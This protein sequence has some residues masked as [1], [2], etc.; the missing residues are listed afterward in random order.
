M[1]KRVRVYQRGGFNAFEAPVMPAMRIA[2]NGANVQKPQYTDEQLV[3]AV[4]GIIGE[5]GG[6]PE[7]ALQQL[8]AAGVDQAKANAVVSSAIEYINQQQGSG[9]QQQQQGPTEEEQAQAE[10]EARMQ[11][12]QQ[13]EADRQARYNTQMANDE[14]DLA[15]SDADIDQ[16]ASDYL[17]R[18]GGALPSKRTFVKNVMKLAKK[19]AGGESEPIKA[20]DT[21]IPGAKGRKFGLDAFVGNLKNKSNNYLQEQDI[22]AMHSMLS[23]QMQTPYADPNSYMQEPEMQ[24]GGLR[25]GQQR[26]MERRANRMAGKVPAA[27]FNAQQQM[28]PQGINIMG[29]PGMMPGMAQMGPK[30]FQMPARGLYAGGPRLANIEVHKTGLFGR[31]KAWTAT[32]DNAGYYDPNQW[33]QDMARMNQANQQT[34][35]KDVY[36]DNKEE[37]TNTSTD[38]N[39]EVKNEE[40]KVEAGTTEGTGGG[41]TGNTT[42]GT[43]GAAGTEGTETPGTEEPDVEEPG[44][45]NPDEEVEVEVEDPTYEGMGIDYARYFPGTQSITDNLNSRTSNPNTT[46]NTNRQS[47]QTQNSSGVK[48][49]LTNGETVFKLKSGDT[50]SHFVNKNGKIYKTGPKIGDSSQWYEIKDPARIQNI[51]SLS[52]RSADAFDLSKSNK[53]PGIND[54]GM[55]FPKPPVEKKQPIN[56][57]AAQDFRGYTGTVLGPERTGFSDK[58]NPAADIGY[59]WK[60]GKLYK[61]PDWSAVAGTE[62]WY[63]ITDPQRI[64]T[65]TQAMKAQKLMAPGEDNK[66]NTQIAQLINNGKAVK[67]AIPSS[68]RFA[69]KYFDPEYKDLVIRNGKLYFE[70]KDDSW[71]EVKDPKIVSTVMKEQSIGS[72]PFM[73]SGPASDAFEMDSS[74]GFQM[75]GLTDQ[76][77]QLYR[78]INGGEDMSIPTLNERNTADPYFAYGGLYRFQGNGD[79]E[80]DSETNTNKGISIDYG[81]HVN[82][83]TGGGNSGYTA[84]NNR[85]NDQWGNQKYLTDDELKTWETATKDD[86]NLRLTDLSFAN[87]D[88][89]KRDPNYKAWDDLKSKGVNVGD[90]REGIDYTQMGQGSQGNTGYRDP[91][92]GWD[93]TG[94]MPWITS[95]NAPGGYYNPQ[96]GAMYPPLFGGRRRFSPPGGVGYAGSWLKQKGMPFDPRT[97]QMLGQMPTDLPLTKLEVTKSSL[98]RKRPKE[99]T[100]YFGN[101]GQLG[102]NLPQGK[103]N[104]DAQQMSEDASP[105]NSRKNRFAE[106]LMHTPGFR[107]IGARMYEQPE[108]PLPEGSEYTE[109]QIPTSNLVPDQ[110]TVDLTGLPE[111]VIPAVTPEEFSF[112]DQQRFGNVQGPL[113]QADS[114]VNNFNYSPLLSMVPQGLVTPEQQATMQNFVGPME[115]PAKPEYPYV[116]EFGFPVSAPAEEY[117]EETVTPATMGPQAQRVGSYVNEFGFPVTQS[118]MRDINGNPVAEGQGI[119]SNIV[120]PMS[121]M[122]NLPNEQDYFNDL[123]LEQNQEQRIANLPPDSESYDYYQDVMQPNRNQDVYPFG[124]QEGMTEEAFG[125]QAA[126]NLEGF[127]PMSLPDESYS[128]EPWLTQEMLDAQEAKSQA[129]SNTRRGNTAGQTG[130]VNE[131]DGNSANAEQA[132]A[133]NLDRNGLFN[134]SKKYQE[135]QWDRFD[136]LLKKRVAEMR[137]NGATEDQIRQFSEKKAQNADYIIRYGVD[138]STLGFL[139]TYYDLLEEQPNNKALAKEFENYLKLNPAGRNFDIERYRKEQAY[140]AKAEKQ[141]EAQRL[142]EQ[143][144]LEQQKRVKS[145]LPS[146]MQNSVGKSRDGGPILPK[147]QFGPTTGRLTTNP[148]LVGFSDIDLLNAQ[149]YPEVSGSVNNVTGDWWSASPNMPTVQE[150]GMLQPEQMTID[151]NQQYNQQMKR[152]YDPRGAAVKFKVKDMYNVDFEKGVNRA[153]AWADQTLAWTGELGDRNKGAQRFNNLNSGIYGST[154]ALKRGTYETNSGLLEPDK[155]GFKGVIRDGGNIKR[156]GGPAYKAGGV[157]YMSADQVK[158]F[159]AEGGELEFV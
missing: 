146:W 92:S 72:M 108:L 75:G 61:T 62:Q 11:E 10:E 153:N 67:M 16:F 132:R 156:Q 56:F 60:N 51:I 76:Q 18:N 53:S 1:K 90:F 148:D 57:V 2:Q 21:D 74:E 112:A 68:E 55:D 13:E 9:Q 7:D 3:S 8:V 139:M 19:A 157:T 64:A 44:V 140:I 98:F 70:V 14:A 48:L 4:M 31:P 152:G 15:D 83:P 78:F 39:A 91:Y 131:G 77:A 135:A 80:T 93:G 114:A 136:D 23:Q 123:Q 99:Y 115:E 20:D 94:S 110:P 104:A 12:Q 43:E 63:E 45:D 150:T 40:A 65:I 137:A 113:S 26:R 129:Q 42:V 107:K 100:M 154:K 50:K 85:V 41:N 49:N 69:S 87:S 121:D 124:D 59:T 5:Q 147:A 126:E 144:K 142:K 81:G 158:K 122:A 88:N 106:R 24:F 111:D 86:P 25:P 96:I 33:L 35:Y 29:M 37:E 6:S 17:M 119:P 117:V 30:A 109:D 133:K 155:M 79:S 36:F 54:F 116:N 130:D 73:P 66:F 128:I 95:S 97:G 125:Q 127:D 118:V 22:N 120:G 84:F 82:Y 145:T 105:L 27:F 38:E 46:T 32:F 149:T 102:D 101:Y 34:E 143:K 28:F 138:E 159:L 89:P 52:G 141:R 151:P 71:V 103:V 58:V 47:N 134:P